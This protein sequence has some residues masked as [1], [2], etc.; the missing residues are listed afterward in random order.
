MQANNYMTL[1]EYVSLEHVHN[2]TGTTNEMVEFFLLVKSIME[3]VSLK[4]SQK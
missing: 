3:S 2:R 1:N 4:K